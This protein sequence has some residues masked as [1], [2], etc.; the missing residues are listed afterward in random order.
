MLTSPTG[1]RKAQHICPCS[2]RVWY[3]WIV[4][5]QQRCRRKRALVSAVVALAWLLFCHWNT[6]ELYN[7][8]SRILMHSLTY[9][10]FPKYAK[11]HKVISTLRS[12]A[13]NL[14]LNPRNK[15][16]DVL[17]SFLYRRARNPSV[18][19]L[20]TYLCEEIWTFASFR[21]IYGNVIVE[22]SHFGKR[23]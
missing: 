2:Q 22:I 7:L 20:A 19:A 1:R 18:N 12:F 15:F 11:I 23:T 17:Q 10:L 13:T 14:H 8:R 16:N 3:P 21:D 6:E 5:S 9:D 4:R